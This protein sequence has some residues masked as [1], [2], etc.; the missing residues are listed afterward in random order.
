[1]YLKR[2][3]FAEESIPGKNISVES[4]KWLLFSETPDRIP[5]FRKRSGREGLIV[6]PVNPD[7]SGWLVSF[8]KGPPQAKIIYSA[9]STGR[10]FHAGR[11][12]KKPTGA[13]SGKDAATP[14]C[15]IGFEFEPSL[16]PTSKGGK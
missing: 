13:L 5:R 2:K 1:M 11:K 3:S 16:V 8:R 15:C 9:L 10:I 4:R 12:R 14:G 6:V 7:K